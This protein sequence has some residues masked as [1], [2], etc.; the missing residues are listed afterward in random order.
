MNAIIK[1]SFE[2]VRQ[3]FLVAKDD[4]LQVTAEFKGKEDVVVKISESNFLKLI[5][6]KS[7]GKTLYMKGE[8]KVS[9]DMSKMMNLDQFTQDLAKKTTNSKL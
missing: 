1:F 5:N 4:K 9:G 3:I 7:S 8:M 6:G 2:G